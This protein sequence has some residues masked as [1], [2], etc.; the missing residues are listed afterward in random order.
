[1]ARAL[2]ISGCFLDDPVVTRRAFGLRDQ[3]GG[4][5]REPVDAVLGPDPQRI[6]R[7]AHGFDGGALALLLDL[8]H[9]RE[10][11]AQAVDAK[12]SAPSGA[13]ASAR[14]CATSWLRSGSGYAA[15][16]RSRAR[17]R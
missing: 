7:A 3:I 5:Q 16:T 9:T 12:M 4:E 2:V 14:Y 8:G 10:I 1:V 15:A 17:R 11:A 13:S 6:P